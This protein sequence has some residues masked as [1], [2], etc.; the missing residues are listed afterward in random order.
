MPCSTFQRITWPS[1]EPD[2]SVRPSRD[3]ST[4][5]TALLHA[6]SIRRWHR[7]DMSCRRYCD[8]SVHDV[9]KWSCC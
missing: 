1:S 2:T 9:S 6:Q 4:P 8:L 5:V 7:L 3:H